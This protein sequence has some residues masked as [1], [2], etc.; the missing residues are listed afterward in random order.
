MTTGATVR[1][2]GWNTAGDPEVRPPA[3][4]SRPEASAAPP[5]QLCHRFLAVVQH[6]TGQVLATGS[7]A[8]VINFPA[9][10][11]RKLSFEVTSSHGTPRVAEY[12]TFA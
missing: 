10:S 3:D 8:G 6:D 5:R 4:P 1:N 12:E 9:T 7:G 11:V 2:P